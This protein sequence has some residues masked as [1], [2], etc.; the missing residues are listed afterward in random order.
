[1]QIRDRASVGNMGGYFITEIST[2][3][4]REIKIK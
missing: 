1:M 2:K 3:S 4:A